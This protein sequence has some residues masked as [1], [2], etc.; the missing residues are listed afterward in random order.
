MW[1]RSKQSITALNLYLDMRESVPLASDVAA[2]RERWLRYRREGKSV[3]LAA[4]SATA[5]ILAM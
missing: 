2:W 4:T 5:S 3:F 1:D